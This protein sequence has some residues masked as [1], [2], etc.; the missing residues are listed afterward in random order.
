MKKPVEST[1]R[2]FIK[3]STIASSAMLLP[4]GNFANLFLPNEII[5]TDILDVSIFSKQL[6]FLDYKSMSEAAKEMG[7]DGIDLTIRPKGH[8]FYCSF[9][10]YLFFDF[11]EKCVGRGLNGL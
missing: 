5:D 8:D 2:K 6:Q 9:G 4:V 1:R 7:F 3:Q 10:I 11:S